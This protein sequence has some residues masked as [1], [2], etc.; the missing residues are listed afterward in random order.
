M[1]SR[2]Y[3]AL[4]YTIKDV[5]HTF[6][7]DYLVVITISKK[8]SAKLVWDNSILWLN[9]NF[10]LGSLSIILRIALGWHSPKFINHYTNNWFNN[11]YIKLANKIH[12]TFL[13]NYLDK[14]RF[15]CFILPRQKLF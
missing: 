12:Y 8:K 10:R 9:P 15:V 7:N 11:L 13:N 2:K 6:D 3:I 5:F 4:V 1:N 14:E